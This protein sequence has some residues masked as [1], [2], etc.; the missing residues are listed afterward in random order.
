VITQ[1]P[2]SISA[3]PAA[4]EPAGDSG[5]RLGGRRGR[6]IAGTA[7]AVLALGAL[8]VALAAARV[9]A[10]PQGPAFTGRV[11]AATWVRSKGK[12][13]DVFILKV[14]IERKDG[15][16]F[17]RG[18]PQV[19]VRNPMTGRIP[20]AQFR[21]W[22]SFPNSVNP[23]TTFYIL[24]IPDSV[25]APIAGQTLRAEMHESHKEPWWRQLF[26]TAAEFAYPVEGGAVVIPPAPPRAS[27]PTLDAVLSTSRRYSGKS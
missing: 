11:A 12:Q 1:E 9:A 10:R 6:R 27:R 22:Q 18:C 15:R 14:R 25:T 8:V 13:P 20:T 4:A 19:D 16:P 5:V 26:G 2:S 23:R 3:D 21:A 17:R 7:A 24:A